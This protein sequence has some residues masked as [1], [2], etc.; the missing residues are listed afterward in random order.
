LTIKI[1]KS[2]NG[3]HTSV[4]ST[5]HLNSQRYGQIMLSIFPWT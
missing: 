5:P 1:K 3:A 4:Q 2:T